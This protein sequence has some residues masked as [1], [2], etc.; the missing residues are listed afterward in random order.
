[1]LV[2][3]KKQTTTGLDWNQI[4][5]EQGEICR[6]LLKQSE[7]PNTDDGVWFTFC[8]FKLYKFYSP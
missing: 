7:G 5:K 8:L 3:T 4:K 6:T 2:I 1:M